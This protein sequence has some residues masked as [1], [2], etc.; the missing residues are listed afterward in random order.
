MECTH[1]AYLVSSSSPSSL[2]TIFQCP[3]RHEMKSVIK[4]RF[5]DN[6][7]LKLYI[8]VPIQDVYLESI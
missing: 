8:E 2:A 6:I 7:S 4:Q 1:C 3:N 5:L